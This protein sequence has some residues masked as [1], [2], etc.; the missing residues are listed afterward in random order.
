M[1]NIGHRIGI[2]IRRRR[3]L[4]FEVADTKKYAIFSSSSE[5]EEDNS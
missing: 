3:A 4:A 2:I 1:S 5:D